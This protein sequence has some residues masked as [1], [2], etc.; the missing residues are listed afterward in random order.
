MRGGN[1]RS[2]LTSV[3]LYIDVGFK[4]TVK[5]TSTN[6]TRFVCGIKDA[7]KES[8]SLLVRLI[9]TPQNSRVN[10]TTSGF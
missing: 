2:S 8:E 10:F 4:D 7:K 9:D 5:C 1:I 6:K 3:V